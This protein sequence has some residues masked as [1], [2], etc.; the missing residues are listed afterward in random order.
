MM[1]SCFEI[2]DNT[3]ELESIVDVEA[4]RQ[5]NGGQICSTFAHRISPQ[6]NNMCLDSLEPAAD[7]LDVLTCMSV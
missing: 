7:S 2:A 4:P 1:V 5:M 3:S 6:T